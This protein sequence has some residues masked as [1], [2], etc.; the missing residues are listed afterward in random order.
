[1][2]DGIA[3]SAV[4]CPRSSAAGSS[5]VTVGGHRHRV[6]ASRARHGWPHREDG[7]TMERDSMRARSRGGAWP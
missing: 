4:E 6:D 2:L 3:A 7:L 1:M 5:A